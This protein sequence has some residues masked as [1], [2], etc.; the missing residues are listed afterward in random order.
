MAK[1]R[2]Y[3]DEL[4][5]D[6][7]L[8]FAIYSAGLALN[9][10]YKPLLSPLGLTYPQYLTMVALWERDDQTV[11]TI[12]ERLSLES[13]T[14]TPLL[15]RLETMGHVRRARD[16][17]DE[18]QVRVSLTQRGKRLRT[19]A[20]EIPACIRKAVGMTDAEIRRLQTS[21]SL[22]RVQLQTPNAHHDGLGDVLPKSRPNS[23]RGT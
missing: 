7:F 3:D 10:F 23:R 8:C 16:A 19:K 1:R 9:R 17:N 14:M 6:D 4:R 18:R 12:A 22:V 15:K 11:G 13:H 20:A 5:L 21:L 2:A